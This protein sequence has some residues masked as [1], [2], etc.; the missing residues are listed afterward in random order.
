[1]NRTLLESVGRLRAS[2]TLTDAQA[3]FFSRVARGELVSVRLELQVAL[4]AGVTLIAAGAGVLV[5]DNLT[6]LGP[7]TIGAGI[8]LAA[9]LCLWYVGHAAPPFSWGP[10][11]SPTLA[12]DYVLLLGVLLIGTDLAYLETQYKILGPNWPWHLLLLSLLQLGFAFRY[13]SRAVLSLGLASFAAWRGVAI[14]FPGG[15]LF[16]RHDTLIR[17]EA[18]VV[19]ALF[20]AAG[21]LI[22]RTGRKAHFEP[23]FGNLG[24]LLVLGAAVAGAYGGSGRLDMAWFTTLAAIAAATVAL[25]YRARRSDYFAQGV[26]AAYLGFLRLAAELHFEIGLFYLVSAGS[27][28]VLLLLLWAHRHFKEE[29]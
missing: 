3:A 10:V 7:V 14:S 25:A 23:A 22:R 19:G 1:M 2:G 29:P 4:W 20:L 21:I 5:K 28:G 9:A 26:I 12:F 11:A 18:L 27:F 16:G 6:H 8:A 13:D 17:V 24:L 15:V